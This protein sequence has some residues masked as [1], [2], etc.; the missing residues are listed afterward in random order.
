M[1]QRGFDVA[2]SVTRMTLDLDKIAL[3]QAFDEQPHGCRWYGR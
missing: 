2:D 3:R 1:S